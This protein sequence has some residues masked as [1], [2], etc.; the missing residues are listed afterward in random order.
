METTQQ[1][2][3][4]LIDDTDWEEFKCSDYDFNWT[5]T[6]GGTISVFRNASTTGSEDCRPIINK[7]CTYTVEEE[8]KTKECVV[9]QEVICTQVEVEH[10][11][12]KIEKQCTPAA[13]ETK[14]GQVCLET[15]TL[16]C[17]KKPEEVC[18]EVLKETCGEV[19]PVEQICSNVTKE[20]C[21]PV[22]T[23][24]CDH[25]NKLS[26]GPMGYYEEPSEVTTSYNVLFFP[27]FQAYRAPNT[28]QGDTN[29]SDPENY[30]MPDNLF[31]EVAQLN[32]SKLPL[33]PGCHPM[34]LPMTATLSSFLGHLVTDDDDKLGQLLQ[35]ENSTNEVERALEIFDP[36]FPLHWMSF[37]WFH[38]I[39]E[40]FKTFNSVM[41]SG[42]HQDKGEGMWW[43]VGE[44]GSYFGVSFGK[45]LKIQKCDMQQSVPDIWNEFSEYLSET[46]Q[47]FS[48]EIPDFENLT[49]HDIFFSFEDSSFSVRSNVSEIVGD[50]NISDVVNNMVDLEFYEGLA[51]SKLRSGYDLIKSG[52]EDNKDKSRASMASFLDN[53]RPDPDMLSILKR[54]MRTGRKL[55]AEHK[56]EESQCNEVNSTNIQTCWEIMV[57]E[58]F[59][60]VEPV[61]IN[62]N[63]ASLDIMLI[64][65]YPVVIAT[66]IL[67]A[68]YG[69]VMVAG[70]KEAAFVNLPCIYDVIQS[71]QIQFDTAEIMDP[72]SSFFQIW[73]NSFGREDFSALPVIFVESAMVI[74]QDDNLS[75]GLSKCVEALIAKMSSAVSTGELAEK[76]KDR[77]TALKEWLLSLD[78]LEVMEELTDLVKTV[79]PY[80]ISLY[81][82]EWT[83]LIDLVD[84][85]VHRVEE[86]LFW[87]RLKELMKSVVQDRWTGYQTLMEEYIAPSIKYTVNFMEWVAEDVEGNLN[88]L[89][90]DIQQSDGVEFLWR[91]YGRLDLWIGEYFICRGSDAE[92]LTEVFFYG[93]LISILGYCDP[94]FQI[95][96]SQNM[97]QMFDVCESDKDDETDEKSA[98]LRRQIEESGV[99]QMV[100]NI[101]LQVMRVKKAVMC[102]ETENIENSYWAQ[103]LI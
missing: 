58:M 85:L 26:E 56:Q 60:S 65:Y 97:C 34:V 25:G 14:I 40:F 72:E 28:T 70:L 86:E 11:E 96:E 48:G 95:F 45:D 21:I 68:G 12:E 92:H 76:I 88:Q 30:N 27:Y 42:G 6:G 75:T 67:W 38:S 9:K 69:V 83:E 99:R 84:S 94:F 50:Y 79:A 29:I 47:N 62:S 5:S 31:A 73:A 17:V 91:Y 101:H 33:V 87:D 80:Y 22:V 98:Q 13:N 59:N 51:Y 63:I 36:D 103:I 3:V 54:S 32:R 74:I 57:T 64:T 61:V 23:H 81:T 77:A 24:V 82:G 37:Q 44:L 102:R 89:A 7:N 10:C 19:D 1:E 16:E 66:I 4:A 46:A 20:K 100:H 78:I 18:E 55:E 49:V 15:P 41:K 90:E 43:L 35:Q 52:T 53:Y 93:Q 2:A 71:E 39:L 8:C